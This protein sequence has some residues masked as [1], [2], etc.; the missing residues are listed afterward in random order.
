[1]NLLFSHEFGWSC[2][3]TV[4]GRDPVYS[5]HESQYVAFALAAKQAVSQLN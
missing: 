1:M 3:L 4:D 2:T 5:N